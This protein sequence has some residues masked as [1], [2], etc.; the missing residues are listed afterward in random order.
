MLLEWLVTD[1]VIYYFYYLSELTE[2]IIC[3]FHYVVV[4]VSFFLHSFL[5][6]RTLDVSGTASYEITLVRLPVRP[7][8]TK[9]SQ[10]WIISFFWYCTWWSLTMIPSD[11]RSQIF[12]KKKKKMAVRIWVKWAKIGP[13][14]R[15]VAISQVWFISFLF[16]QIDLFYSNVFKIGLP[17][18]YV[19]TIHNYTF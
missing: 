18:I 11:W 12:K 13:E 16:C 14:T 2:C 4:S 7:S 1:L 10:D 3:E 17:M 15:F 6:F 19:L 5:L 8:V 9:F